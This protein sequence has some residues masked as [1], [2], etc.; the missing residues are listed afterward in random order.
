MKSQAETDAEIL[1]TVKQTDNELEEIRVRNTSSTH[2][3]DCSC[4]VCKPLRFKEAIGE[5]AENILKQQLDYY[6]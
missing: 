4:P 6:R 2:P 3:V 1:S 5:N